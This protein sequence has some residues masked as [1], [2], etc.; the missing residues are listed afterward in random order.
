MACHGQ[1]EYHIPRYS[2]TSSTQW[3]L[4]RFDYTAG[5]FSNSCVEIS[6]STIVYKYVFIKMKLNRATRSTNTI[7]VKPLLEA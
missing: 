1:Q 6:H 3:F 7:E 2:Q 4:G 5:D